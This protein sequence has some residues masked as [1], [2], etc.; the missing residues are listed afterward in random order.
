VFQLIASLSKNRR[1]LKDFIGRDLKARYVGS[2]MGF[3]WSVVFPIINLF[4][5]MF[6]FRMILNSRFQDDASDTNVAIWMLAGITVWAAFGES[7][8]R[9]T[10]CLVENANLIQKVVF[11]SE[12]LPAYL[13]V[14]SLI[15]MCIGLPIVLLG[16]IYFTYI[17]PEELVEVASLAQ[18]VHIKEPDPKTMG[19]GASIVLLPVLMLLQAVFT[20]GLSYFLS[21]FN[22][23]VRDTYHVIGVLVTVWMF[24]TPIFYP[25]IMVEQGRDGAFAWIL[26]VN[27]MHWLISS[28]RDLLV[29]GDWPDALPLVRFGVVALLLF[30]V[31]STFFM[32]QKRQFPDLL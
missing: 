5:Y 13:T 32:R 7:L 19:L 24:S 15:N 9:C 30:V 12:L 10:N 18:D 23:F 2:A 14:S 8:S 20:M 22:L 3:F 11:P 26:D 6:V 4:V 28:Y 29:F 27:P 21:A 1:L 25:A 16:T 17:S 31:G